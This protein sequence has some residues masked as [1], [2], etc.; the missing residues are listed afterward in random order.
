MRRATSIETPTISIG[1]GVAAYGLFALHDATIKW[2]V[3]ELPVW[4]V[5]FCR[6]VA[7]VVGCLAIGRAKL[8]AR[9]VATPLKANLALRGNSHFGSTSCQIVLL[10][11]GV[12]GGLAQF[13]LFEGCRHAPA[14]VMATV[15]Y[16]AL[17]WAFILGYVIWGDIPVPA[18]FIGAGLILLAGMLL[19]LAEQ[20]ATRLMVALP[21]G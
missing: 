13:A 4:Q 15:E 19:V 14:S 10:A 6:S 11:V 8:L 3:A 5:L 12:L 1:L 9:A 20:R 18:V 21:E 17:I 7:I 2:L 16:T